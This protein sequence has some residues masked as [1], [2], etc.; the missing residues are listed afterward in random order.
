MILGLAEIK[1]TRF[2]RR[3]INELERETGGSYDYL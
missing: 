2:L 1:A 3:E